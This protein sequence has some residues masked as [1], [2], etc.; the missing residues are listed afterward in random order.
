MRLLLTDD[1][2]VAHLHDRILSHENEVYVSTTSWWE[3]GIRIGVGKLQ[4]D[5]ATLRRAAID[6]GYVELPVLGANV[7]ELARLP[8][9]H[10]DP[11]DRMLV[12]QAN[13]ESMRLLTADAALSAYGANVE[14]I[15]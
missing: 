9:V 2:R 7:E 1:L 13:G 3:A 5:V 14:L 4:A 11:F 8:S 12:A 15:A 10:P 6:S